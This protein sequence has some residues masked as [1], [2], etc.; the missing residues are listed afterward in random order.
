MPSPA[1]RSEI[2]AARGL[3]RKGGKYGFLALF[4]LGE[5]FIVFDTSGD[6]SSGGF[7]FSFFLFQSAFWAIWSFLACMFVSLLRGTFLISK[8]VAIVFGVLFAYVVGRYLVRGGAPG[9]VIIGRQM[10]FAETMALLFAPLV[11][12]VLIQLVMFV[13]ALFVKGDKDGDRQLADAM[14][15]DRARR[16][17][18]RHR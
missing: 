14:R 5:I 4:I 7:D 16:S 13:R 17:D 12:G 11:G 6:I 1:S 2:E 3:F 15:R 9:F 18:R 10:I 8:P